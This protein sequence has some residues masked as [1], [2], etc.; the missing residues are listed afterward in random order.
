MAKFGYWDQFFYL[1]WKCFESLKNR[2]EGGPSRDA[3]DSDFL[4]PRLRFALF[5]SPP[6]GSPRPRTPS[7]P[8]DVA[9]VHTPHSEAA[10]FPRQ[11]RTFQT[12]FYKSEVFSPPPDLLKPRLRRPTIGPE[13]VKEPINARRASP[14]LVDTSA[15]PRALWSSEEAAGASR[16]LLGAQLASPRLA[17]PSRKC[18]CA[19][20]GQEGESVRARERASLGRAGARE[21]S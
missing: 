15:P 21:L 19:Q 18:A 16:V 8:N 1:L 7:I 3:A 13:S 11:P 14:R 5:F 9:A 2:A 4:R 10:P 17:L 20:N 12:P 6:A